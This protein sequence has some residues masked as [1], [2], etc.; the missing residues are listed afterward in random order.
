M[1]SIA[2]R[3]DGFIIDLWG[4]LHDGQTPYDGALE[5]LRNLKARGR[6]I[7]LLSNSSEVAAAVAAE[8]RAIGFADSLYDALVTSGGL[9]GHALRGDASIW[10]P[11]RQGKIFLVG[12]P[13]NIA[14][15]GNPAL[16]RVKTPEQAGLVLNAWYDNEWSGD[17]L[18]NCHAWQADMQH[19]QMLG[20]PM[21]C[22]NPDREVIHFGRRV[23]C[24][25]IFA[26]AYE[27]IGGKVFYY[28]KPH[29]SA[30]RA[31]VQA[32]ALPPESNLAMI[33][34]NLLTDI[35][36]GLDFGLDTILITGGVHCAAL[37]SAWGTM[38]APEKLAA[39]CAAHNLTP[40][41]AMPRLVFEG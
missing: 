23:L 25:G 39:L 1:S 10:L 33:G 6:K 30:F 12:A 16:R 34:D 31:A 13:A 28:G 11:G 27:A 20:L 38:P 17:P 8:L 37:E 21:I 40:A 36:G 24:P 14:Q 7:A 26:D 22:I 41:M 32:L 15:F 9:V 35:K 2:D 4:V 29:A 19:W 5:A 3:Y 18:G